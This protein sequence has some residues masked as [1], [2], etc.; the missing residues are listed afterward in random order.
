MSKQID[1]IR[2]LST[3][4]MQK[5]PSI[6]NSWHYSYRNSTYINI[7]GLDTRLTEGDVVVA[8]S[9]FGDVDDVLLLREIDSGLSRGIAF[10][11]YKDW[12][13]CCLAVDNMN[14]YKLVERV[15]KVDHVMDF[16]PPNQN[17]GP[18]YEK[19][20]PWGPQGR[21]FVT[22]KQSVLGSLVEKKSSIADTDQDE[23][24]DESSLLKRGRH[25]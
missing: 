2:K 14:G 18:K 5:C 12:K 19:S 4:E 22:K 25:K 8:F 24:D 16:R 13:S 23:T 21:T 15:L 1:A 20:G 7:T 6:E 3:Q 10:V 17:S 9:Q 11:S